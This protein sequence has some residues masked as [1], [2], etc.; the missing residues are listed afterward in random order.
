MNRN[1][2]SRTSGAARRPWPF[3]PP[4]WGRASRSAA[5]TQSSARMD[6]PFRHVCSETASFG[7][8]PYS[9]SFRCVF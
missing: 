3:G 8:L 5:G 1:H 7:G 4:L 9:H 2:E 6:K